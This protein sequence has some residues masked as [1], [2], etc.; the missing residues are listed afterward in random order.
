MQ[1]TAATQWYYYDGRSTQG[2]VGIERLRTLQSQFGP[3]LQVRGSA[4]QA[5]VPV[6]Q[7]TQP[8]PS[9]AIAR[10]AS[11]PKKKWSPLR[12]VGFG[13]GGISVAFVLLI[14]LI[15]LRLWWGADES[16]YE[17]AKEDRDQCSD[18]R[19][20]IKTFPSRMNAEKK[21]SAKRKTLRKHIENLEESNLERLSDSRNHEVE[22]LLQ[23]YVE[24]LE[25]YDRALKELE[26]AGSVETLVEEMEKSSEKMGDVNFYRNRLAK[27]MP[28]FCRMYDEAYDEAKDALDD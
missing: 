23:D 26:Y 11:K 1:S 28:D 5:W 6:C 18:A 27:E 17:T 21:A 19:K 4:G 9:S 14:G 15:F 20:A 12:V 3:N 25:E 22:R 16:R 24:S 2:P 7:V 13:C 10:V 8:A